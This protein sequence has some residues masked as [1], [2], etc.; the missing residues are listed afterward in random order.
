MEAFELDDLCMGCMS[1]NKTGSVCPHCGFD[2]NTPQNGLVLPYQTILNKKFLIGRVL[3]KGGFGIT[4][5][6][7]DLVLQTAVAIKEFMPATLVTRDNKRPFMVA[8]SDEAQ[9]EFEYGL[10]QFLQEARTLA[11]FSH[12]N[13]VRVREFFPAN[14]TAYLVM[15]YYKGVSLQQF[16]QLNNRKLTEREALKIML[17][18]LN[19]LA[20]VHQ[21]GFLHRDIKPDNIYLVGNEHP[22]LL[23]FGAARSAFSHKSLSMSVILTPGFAPFEQYL[24]RSNFTASTDIYSVAATI[25]YMVSSVKPSEATARLQNDPLIPLDKLEPTVT[26]K[27]AVSIMKAL[28]VYPE[29]RQQSIEEFEF[30]L[31]GPALGGTS[32]S[33][34]K[35]PSHL[36]PIELPQ[37][38]LGLA[39]LE[40]P[41]P[42]GKKYET[43]Y[44]PHCKTKNVIREGKPLAEIRCIKCRKGPNE[45]VRKPISPIL[46]IKVA[47]ALPVLLIC[48]RFLVSGVLTEPAVEEAIAPLMPDLSSSRRLTGSSSEPV[49]GRQDRGG[50]APETSNYNTSPKTLLR[51]EGL[52]P[53]APGFAIEACE[54][55]QVNDSCVAQSPRRKISGVCEQVRGA[56]ACIPGNPKE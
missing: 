16:L 12:A 9:V 49:P 21:K 41:F 42:G 26:P 11:Q 47:L 46:L 10:K 32:S 8:H 33:V 15:D 53:A 7:W 31:T 17:P 51:R 1:I 54:G 30:H 2:K 23:D 28:S 55:K 3:G 5:L 44:C 36:P 56:L 29:N 18:V 27:F 25:Y 13:V 40:E 20:Q 35:R 48:Y 19:G 14:K 50:G 4:Y 52:L 38:P 37:T 34:Y 6:A 43:Y 22:V 39:P 24:S 45:K